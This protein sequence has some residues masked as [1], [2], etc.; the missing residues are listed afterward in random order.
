M[1]R[2]DG[3]GPE[4]ERTTPWHWKSRLAT[5]RTACPRRG[6]LGG[7]AVPDPG[8]QD[9][10]LKGQREMPRR[11]AASTWKVQEERLMEYALELVHT[12]R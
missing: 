2:G 7:W 5:R 4:T 3:N 8:R 11:F 12:A 10:V 1:L 6:R 9:T